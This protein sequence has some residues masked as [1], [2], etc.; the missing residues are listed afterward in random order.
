MVRN[1]SGL[2]SDFSALNIISNLF[3]NRRRLCPS[4]QSLFAMFPTSRVDHNLMTKVKRLVAVRRARTVTMIKID[5]LDAAEAAEKPHDNSP[6]TVFDL[7]NDNDIS[8][9]EDINLDSS[10]LKAVV[11]KD[12]SGPSPIFAGFTVEAPGMSSSTHMAVEDEEDIDWDC[13]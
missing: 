3:R 10:F 1:P 6:Q 13:I 11:P 5:L 12:T 4:L 8:L 9:D 7:C 2:F